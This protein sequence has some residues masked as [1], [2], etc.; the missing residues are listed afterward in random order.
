MLDYL[1]NLDKQLLLFL[2]GLHSPFWDWMMFW[3]S[4]KFTFIP[5]YAA[6]IF[7]FFKKFGRTGWIILVMA[8]LTLTLSDQI[9]VHLFK[10]VFERLRPTHTPGLEQLIH[11]VRDQRGGMYGFVSSHAANT[12]SFAMFSL[13]VFRT[14]WYTIAILCWA[15]VVSYTRIYMGL[16]FPGDILGGAIVGSLIGL[17]VYTVMRKLPCYETCPT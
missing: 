2:N 15:L 3:I 17:S 7:F 9:S 11:L 12:F 14:R 4:Y 10:N 6:V 8:I 13:L 1:I 5:L 16:H